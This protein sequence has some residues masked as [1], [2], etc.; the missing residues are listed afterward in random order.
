MLQW[1]SHESIHLKE[2]GIDVDFMRK[3]KAR[4]G[5]NC[6]KENTRTRTGWKCH[7]CFFINDN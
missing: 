3:K 1:K 7:L 5:R 4:H 6:H 2:Q